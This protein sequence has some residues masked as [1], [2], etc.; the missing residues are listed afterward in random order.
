MLFFGHDIFFWISVAGATF[1]RVVTSERHSLLR[2]LFS[3]FAAVFAACIFT[4]PSIDYLNLNPMT[5]TAP[6]AALWALTGEGVMRW[7]INA[8]GQPL[9]FVKSVFNMWKGK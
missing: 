8:S 5:Y 9:E 2:S 6:V 7:I 1:V 4:A 3:V